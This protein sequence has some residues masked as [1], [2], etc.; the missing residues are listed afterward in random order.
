M[1]KEDSEAM[2]TS[3]PICCQGHCL[4]YRLPRR[5]SNR[6]HPGGLPERPKG[7]DCK[8][9]GVCLRRF[10]PCTRHVAKK[11][12][13]TW[14]DAGLGA[15]FVWRRFAACGSRLRSFTRLMGLGTGG[16][17]FTWGRGR[18]GPGG[19]GGG[20]R[21]GGGWGGGGGGGAPRGGGCGGGG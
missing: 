17:A 7:A 19:R 4:L 20:G 6:Q 13:L 11:P 10:E 16:G 9:V 15:V 8:S 12:S 14:A 3:F 1:S 18:L 5:F 21:G 2:G